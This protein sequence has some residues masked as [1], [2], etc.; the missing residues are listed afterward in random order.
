[1]KRSYELLRITRQDTEE[2]RLDLTQVHIFKSD[3]TNCCCLSYPVMLMW[4]YTITNTYKYLLWKTLYS[5]LEF[6]FL[7]HNHGNF[8]AFFYIEK[9][10][11]LLIKFKTAAAYS[12]IPLIN[13]GKLTIDLLKLTGKNCKALTLLKE[14]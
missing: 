7:S 1:M 4:T 12:N 10:I 5:I 9:I 6:F 14:L 8:I 11:Y 13:N 2:R 3:A